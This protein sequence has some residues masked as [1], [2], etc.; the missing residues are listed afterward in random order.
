MDDDDEC[1]AVKRPSR[2]GAG[3]N[4]FVSPD[5]P[6][7]LADGYRN[8]RMAALFVFLFEMKRGFAM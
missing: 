4:P 2:S 8:R 3:S 1:K 6:E 5:G 7:R